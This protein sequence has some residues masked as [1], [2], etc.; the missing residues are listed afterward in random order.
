MKLA[1]ALVL[2]TWVVLGALEYA[3]LRSVPRLEQKVVAH[4][5]DRTIGM[6]LPCAEVWAERE[7]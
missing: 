2:F 7:I 3:T 4:C 1:I 5:L 6:F